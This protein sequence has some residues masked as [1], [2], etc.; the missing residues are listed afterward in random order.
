M[1]HL[2]SPASRV[3]SSRRCWRYSTGVRSSKLLCGRSSLYS[4]R[5]ASMMRCL[6]GSTA[7]LWHLPRI[8]ACLAQTCFVRGFFPQI[9]VPLFQSRVTHATPRWIPGDGIHRPWYSFTVRNAPSRARRTQQLILASLGS[10]LSPGSS[11][12]PSTSSTIARW[13]GAEASARS[14]VRSRAS[15]ASARAM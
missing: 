15:R 4:F 12:Q 5:Q 9:R 8:P 14:Q 7:T 2:P 11:L 6:P 10:S 3:A 13:P 1:R